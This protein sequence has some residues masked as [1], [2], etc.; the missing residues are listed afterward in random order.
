M[1]KE[2][3]NELTQVLLRTRPLVQAVRERLKQK[4]GTPIMKQRIPR[5]EART[6][7]KNL[8]PEIVQGLVQ[9]FGEQAVNDYLKREMQL[10]RRRE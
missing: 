5:S 4:A 6:R 9:K 8:T 3:D 7:Y 1:T 2:I 10:E